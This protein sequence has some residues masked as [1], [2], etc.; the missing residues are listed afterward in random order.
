MAPWLEKIL[1]LPNT[2]ALCLSFT[3]YCENYAVGEYAGLAV[4]MKKLFIL[5]IFFM[6]PTSVFALSVDPPPDFPYRRPP[7]ATLGGVIQCDELEDAG[8]WLKDNRERW[9]GDDPAVKYRSGRNLIRVTHYGLEDSGFETP[10]EYLAHLQNLF[11]K[12]ESIE[13][14][15][16]AGREAISAR[17]RYEHPE[18]TGHHGEYIPHEYSYEEFIIVPMDQADQGFLVFNLTLHHSVPM[19][20]IFHEEDPS[21]EEWE[22][23]LAKKV[24][25][26]KKFLESCSINS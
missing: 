19:R 24:K 25:T 6:F 21:A 22:K 14:T 15:S 26:W 12:P 5:S 10:E 18:Y 23:E 7:D 16:L 13:P 17:L 11:D 2:F 4:T 20:I 8:W 3:V 9:L 1:F